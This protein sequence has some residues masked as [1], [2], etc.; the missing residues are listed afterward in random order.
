MNNTFFKTIFYLKIA[1]ILVV[2]FAV[3]FLVGFYLFNL[4]VR[5]APQTP[6]QTR[7]IQS[8]NINN[9]LKKRLGNG[10]DISMESYDEWAN[11]YG[12]TASDKDLD[13]DPDKD[14]LANYLEY[15]HGTNPLGA[16]TDGDGFYDFKEIQNGFDPDAPGETK[17]MVYVNIKKMEVNAPMI[18]SQTDDDQKMLADLEKGLSHFYQTAAPGQNGNAVLSGHSSNYIWAKGNYNHIFENLNLLE[19]GDAV[20]VRIIQQNGRIMTYRYQVTDKFVTTA[21]DPKVFADTE[22]PTLTLS[23]CWPI[24]TNLK[25]LIIKTEIVK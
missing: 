22:N 7:L 20:Y 8:A 14:G 4:N 6:D 17:P 23:T 15:V 11:R 10:T 12:L 13:A 16:D 9:E 18:W 21:D 2:I 3:M 1:A 5:P 19:K 25:R 24:G